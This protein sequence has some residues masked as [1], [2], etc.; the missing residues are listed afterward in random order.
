MLLRLLSAATATLLVTGLAT[1]CGGEPFPRPGYR[2]Y[3]AG[4]YYVHLPTDWYDAG[5]DPDIEWTAPPG[6]GP[7]TGI[8]TSPDGAVVVHT[9]WDE[10]DQGETADRWMERDEASLEREAGS[11]ERLSLDSGVDD[12]LL[13]DGGTSAVL[14]FDA[15]LE[16]G[17]SHWVDV[18]YDDRHRRVTQKVLVQ[19]AP[20]TV[21][22]IRVSV[23]STAADEHADT[24]EVIVDSFRPRPLD[25]AGDA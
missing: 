16:G 14:V 12:G 2:L 23:P 15:V 19:P 4:T 9:I 6:G 25:L 18:E 24:I 11:Y 8:I 7:D 5:G 17:E 21:F 3:R 13:G 22:A 1:A 20:A 10:A